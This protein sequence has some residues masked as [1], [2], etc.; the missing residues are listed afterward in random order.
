MSDVSNKTVR[1][2]AA[3]ALENP[4][5]RALLAATATGSLAFAGATMMAGT[6]Q[7]AGTA[8]STTDAVKLLGQA[9]ADVDISTLPRIKQKLVPPPGVPEHDQVAK[10]GPKIVEVEM[11][12][13]EKKVEIDDNGTTIWAFAYEGSVPGPL[14]VCHQGDYIELTLK[15]DPSNMLEHN[16]DFHAST[17][18]LGGGALTLILPGEQ[19][20]LRFRAL[21]AGTFTYHCA[22]GGE[23][24]PYHVVHGMNG[25]IMVL[26][27]DGLTDGNGTALHYD[28]AYFIGEQDYYIPKDAQGNFKDYPT[29]LDDFSDSLDTMRGL[30]PSHVVFNGR[31]GA[32]AGDNAM[33]AKVGETVLFIHNQ[34][35]RDSRPHLIGGHGD[36]VWEAGNLA[37]KPMTGIETWFIRGGSAGAALYTF[38]QPGTYAYVT[39]NLIEAVLLGGLAHVKV[40]GQWDNKVMEQVQPPT[41]M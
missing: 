4:K 19:V 21:K 36:Y 24:I 1:A 30:V 35:N 37:D 39:H 18:A 16:I 32:L 7:A 3:D 28:R 38:V 20:K 13:I 26:P 40:E 33:T 11:N 17:G 34:A 25:A 6:S 22:P 12:I 10:G 31:A 23:M 2:S 27:R 15:N 41:K 29:A 8:T 14:I 5:R 9:T